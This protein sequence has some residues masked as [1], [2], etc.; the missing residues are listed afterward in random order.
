MKNLM[1]AFGIALLFSGIFAVTNVSAQT[2][3]APAKTTA[4]APAKNTDKVVGKDAKGHTIYQGVKGGQYY[5]NDK[6]TKTYLP[7]GTKVT[8]TTPAK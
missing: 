8:P 4:P 5:M 1:K 6:G 2:T 3:P 7:K